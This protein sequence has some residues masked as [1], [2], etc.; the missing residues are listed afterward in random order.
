[1]NHRRIR[2]PIHRPGCGGPAVSQGLSLFQ[3]VQIVHEPAFLAVDHQ[4]L[5]E[6][7]GL[8]QPDGGLVIPTK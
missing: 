3:T 5:R 2:R 8:Q 6:A 7:H 1:M 4:L